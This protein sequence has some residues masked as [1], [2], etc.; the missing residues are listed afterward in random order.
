MSEDGRRRRDRKERVEGNAFLDV[1]RDAFIRHL[2]LEK[3]REVEDVRETLGFDQAHAMEEAGQFP[4]RGRYVALWVQKWREGV[5]SCASEADPGRLF[6][7]IEGAIAAAL[8]DEEEA[9]R[10]SGDRPLDE[11]REYKAFVDAAVERLL[12]QAA[13][14]T[15][16]SFR[17]W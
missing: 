9:R 11:D 13:A 14:E 6:A 12:R 15:G 5:L 3:W 8:R 4:A 16:T 7:A 2:A 1:A 17:G 10:S